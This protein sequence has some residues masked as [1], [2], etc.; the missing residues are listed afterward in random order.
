MNDRGDMKMEDD[1]E[2]E[3]AKLGEEGND[4]V[5]IASDESDDSDEIAVCDADTGDQTRI[6]KSSE[7]FGPGVNTIWSKR[8]RRKARRGGL[9]P[10]VIELLG[11]ANEAYICGEFE[12]AITT[13]SEVTRLAPKLPDSYHIM[14]LMYEESGDKIRALQLYAIAAT[15]MKSNVDAWQKVANLANEL[16][17]YKQAFEAL[18]SILRLSPNITTYTQKSLIEI[19]LGYGQDAY[20][21]LLRIFNKYPNEINFAIDFA[22]S[23]FKK[24]L[25]NKG[26]SALIRYIFIIFGTQKLPE[27]ILIEYGIP[28]SLPIEEKEK[29]DSNRIFY[30]IHLLLDKLLLNQIQ[31]ELSLNLSLIIFDIIIDFIQIQ[32]S[33]IS[34]DSYN[35]SEYLHL[36]I[37]LA[38][39]YG[40]CRLKA[41]N[42]NHDILYALKLIKPILKTLDESDKRNLIYYTS[43]QTVDVDV[44]IE[45]EDTSTLMNF[46]ID[47]SQDIF[48]LDI[49]IN[50]D[51]TT[52]NNTINPTPITEN[53]TSNTIPT[54]TKHKPK[55][56]EDDHIID[57]ES[58]IFLFYQQLRISE[59]LAY[60]GLIS[61]C[62]HILC[63][64]ICNPILPLL[65]DTL[66]RADVWHRISTI[67]ESCKQYDSSINALLQSIIEDANDPRTLHHFAQLSIQ[68]KK[69][70]ISQAQDLLAVHFITLGA[71]YQNT[72]VEMDRYL[73]QRQ[74]M[75]VM[76][77]STSNS[78]CV[79]EG[80]NER[81]S[82]EHMELVEQENSHVE[83]EVAVGDDMMVEGSERFAGIPCDDKNRNIQISDTNNNTNITTTSN[84]DNED[85]ATNKNSNNSNPQGNNHI[86]SSH[87]RIEDEIRALV[88]WCILLR[89]LGQHRLFL[90]CTMCIIKRWKES[91][92]GMK[93]Y[94]AERKNKPCTITTLRKIFINN[95]NL[96]KKKIILQQQQQQ[97]QEQQQNLNNISEA[98]IDREILISLAQGAGET[99]ATLGYIDEVEKLR[100]TCMEAMSTASSS[101]NRTNRIKRKKAAVEARKQAEASRR[102]TENK[103]DA[104]ECN[105]NNGDGGGGGDDSQEIASIVR[106]EVDIEDEVEDEDINHTDDWDWRKH[107]HTTDSN[108]AFTKRDAKKRIRNNGMDDWRIG[109]FI[110][111]AAQLSVSAREAA[112]IFAADP[113]DIYSANKLA[114]I[115]LSH[116]NIRFMGQILSLERTLPLGIF[117]VSYPQHVTAIFLSGHELLTR[118]KYAEAIDRYMTA[119]YMSP[120]QPIIALCLCIQLIFL[121]SHPIVNCRHT[122]LMK[123]FVIALRYASL[124]RS[125]QSEPQ[126]DVEVESNARNISS[127]C[128]TNS[129]EN[130][131]EYLSNIGLQQEI[132][133]NFGRIFDE[134]NLFHLAVDMYAQTLELADSNPIL[135]ESS[136]SLNLT[137]EAAHNL[138]LIYKRSRSYDLATHIMLKY[139]TF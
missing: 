91:A 10:E 138:I 109:S 86:I 68:Y 47:E 119:M 53:T 7:L 85:I 23:C 13:L 118:R 15:N 92:E 34:I 18:K 55:N 122:T 26:I 94:C 11:K 96:N 63:S 136:C 112:A 107:I 31:S 30:S 59:E 128:K 28:E 46:S 19:Q 116:K 6:V 133:Y 2:Q 41:H 88:Q 103:N 48:N 90:C 71:I 17:Q 126:V 89:T 134:L 38:L 54:N 9:R 52:N 32:N 99:F 82:D 80:V 121:S 65:F 100:K 35:K 87:I 125:C 16:K 5:N 49:N 139:L 132:L 25:I 79:I 36:P 57:K 39:L 130:D 20:R 37:D 131:I 110:R 40:I 66:Q 104:Q 76:K 44:H 56:K 108:S 106:V 22:E 101:S 70:M 115:I 73:Q 14:G 50:D 98:A 83:V 75:L 120:N 27:S 60:I 77:T 102:S 95:T 117:S 69:D 24:G 123:G 67:Y 8:S 33:K 12:L 1:L 129:T 127:H 84:D 29:I 51:F 21:T 113:N 45:D 135:F 43:E 124:R 61:E 114:R 3:L 93:G 78:T 72:C 81:N 4:E 58:R 62:S 137:R 42:N 105:N 97:Q 111:A 74:Q 64:I